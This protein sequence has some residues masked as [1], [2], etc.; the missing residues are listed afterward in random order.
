[1]ETLRQLLDR[2]DLRLRR[3]LILTNEL[4][5]QI[6]RKFRLSGSIKVPQGGISYYEDLPDKPKINGIELVGDMTSKQLGLV[7]QQAYATSQEA[8]VVKVGENLKIDEGVL[9]VETT[10]DAEE[11]NTKPMTSA[12]VYVELGN[13]NILLSKI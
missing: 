9:S 5:G 3:K 2:Q 6:T 4:N 10:N 8:G 12:G 13:I 7:D 1:M 11:D